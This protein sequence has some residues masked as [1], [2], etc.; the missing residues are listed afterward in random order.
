M[1]YLPETSGPRR[2]VIDTRTENTKFVHI[3]LRGADDYNSD[4]LWKITNLKETEWE[5]YQ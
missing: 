2:P 3:Q 4:K 1:H 5:I